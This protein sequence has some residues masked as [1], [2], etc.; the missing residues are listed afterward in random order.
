MASAAL[1]IQG[2]VPPPFGKAVDVSERLPLSKAA[3]RARTPVESR[4]RTRGV[5]GGNPRLNLTT[6]Q[7]LVK[8]VW[9]GPHSSSKLGCVLT[10]VLQVPG[11]VGAARSTSLRGACGL[12]TRA[13][14]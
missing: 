11:P 10:R 12:R 8:R 3:R 5:R 1:K 14:K 9:P 4:G 13:A 7:P 6:E 2:Y